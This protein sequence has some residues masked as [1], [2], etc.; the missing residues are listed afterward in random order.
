MKP[1]LPT[2][3]TSP[4]KL[5]CTYQLVS[6]D[7]N[8]SNAT[9]HAIQAFKAHFIAILA[10]IDTAFLTNRWDLLL[11]HAELTVNLL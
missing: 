9:E 3:A 4:S 6:P 8:R 2:A 7:M 1:A 11:P 5:H 10:G